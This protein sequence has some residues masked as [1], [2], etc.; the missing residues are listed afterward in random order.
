[1][2]IHED[3]SVKGEAQEFKKLSEEEHEKLLTFL[4]SSSLTK[5]CSNSSEK[6]MISELQR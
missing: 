2:E 5:K 6:L 1:M 4:K 3:E